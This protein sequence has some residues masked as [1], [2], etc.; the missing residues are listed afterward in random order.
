[1]AKWLTDLISHTHTHTLDEDKTHPHE[2]VKQSLNYTSLTCIYFIGVVLK[3]RYVYHQS[4]S[5]ILTYDSEYVA[6]EK[7]LMGTSCRAQLGQTRRHTAPY[8]RL[9][10]FV[11]L[12]FR[13][14]FRS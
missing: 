9:L 1:M 5:I 6:H 2:E 3:L 7:F 11:S 4:C 13:E 10:S 8:A 12:F 14:L